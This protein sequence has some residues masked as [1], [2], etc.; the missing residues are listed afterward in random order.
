LTLD[1]HTKL[2]PVLPK[3]EKWGLSNQI[4]RSSKSIGANIAEGYGRFYFMD[5][6]RFCYNARGSL[7][8]T[9]NH[10]RIALD[11]DICPPELYRG[12]RTQAEDVRKLLNGYISWL[13]QQKT[14]EKEPGQTCMSEIGSDNM[15]KEEWKERFDT[16]ARF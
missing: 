7:D 6:V 13:K 3:D 1:I 16:F 10:L 2:V 14:G 11:L 9:V 8:E 15:T 4:Q 12:L 5:N